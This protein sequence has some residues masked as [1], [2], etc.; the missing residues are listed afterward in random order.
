VRFEGI[1]NEDPTHGHPT[2]VAV[3]ARTETARAAA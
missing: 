1:G 2:Q 3:F